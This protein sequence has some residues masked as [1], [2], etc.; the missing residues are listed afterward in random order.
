MFSCPVWY[1]FKWIWFLATM[2]EGV[3][4]GEAKN[5]AFDNFQF[6]LREEIKTTP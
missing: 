1:N 2:H 6:I 5:S 3:G 4:V